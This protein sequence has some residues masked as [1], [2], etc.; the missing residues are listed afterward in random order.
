MSVREPRHTPE[1]RYTRREVLDV[2][3]ADGEALVLLANSRVAR[4]SAI[5]WAC[6]ELLEEP[7]TIG[8]LAA[9]LERRFGPPLEGETLTAVTAV[10]EELV[11]AGVLAEM[12]PA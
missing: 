10:L 5:G 2:L 11:R 3:P 6:Y 4:L 9:E 12:N 1:P 8:D 7:A